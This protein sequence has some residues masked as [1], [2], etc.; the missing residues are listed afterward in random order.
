MSVD[1]RVV[2][3]SPTYNEAENVDALAD[4]VLAQPGGF[5]LLV[6]DDSSP[7][8]T[9]ERVLERAAADPRVD[10]L[11]RPGKEGYGRAV[12]AGLNEA[13]RRGADVVVQMDADGSHDPAV[14]PAM[15]DALA[16]GFDVVVG[17]RYVPGGGIRRWP[18]RRKLLS[19]G[20][21]AYVDR[22]LGLPVRDCTTGFRAF[23]ADALRRCDP[24]AVQAAGYAF[25]IEHLYHVVQQGLRIEEVPIVFTDRE[26]GASSLTW[27]VFT[28][29]VVNPW[30]IRLSSRR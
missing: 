9:G 24:A 8:G 28:E 6:V 11:T 7:D 3:I 10:L 17:S 15:L 25:L 23:S 22:V 29:S 5:S 2:V 4:G 27:S 30:R 21:N 19:R 14:I 20:A 1:P 13:L 18:M 26:Q 12:A 16:A